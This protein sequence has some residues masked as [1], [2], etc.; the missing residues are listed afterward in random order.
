[1]CVVRRV[2]LRCILLWGCMMVVAGTAVAQTQPAV[3]NDVELTR[4]IVFGKGGGRELKLHLARSKK[5]GSAKAPAIVWIHGGGWSGGSRDGGVGNLIQWA[6]RGYVAASIEYRLSGEAKFPAQIEDCK[7]AIRFLRANAEKYGIDPDRVGVA[8]HSAGG[9]LA[10]LLGTSGDLK[11][12]EGTGGS[13]AFSSKVQAVCTLSGPA[14]FVGWGKSVHPAVRG[15]LGAR[16]EDVPA[17]A[18]LASP[19][20]HVK[21]T[22]PPFLIIH[23]DQDDVVPVT[24]GRAMHAALEKVGAK[25]TLIIMEGAKHFPYGPKTTEAMNA[26]F[27]EHL[28]GTSATT[29]AQP[30]R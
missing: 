19:V 14:D 15:L 26:F 17:M 18:A 10:A 27:D 23:G 1:M 25:T 30:G 12:L 7:C 3:P 29:K 11:E 28:R 22:D 21:K 5:Q 16:V 20:T 2:V 24:Q 8:G 4:D 6:R 9:H 13:P